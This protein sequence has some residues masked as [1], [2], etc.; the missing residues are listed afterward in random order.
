VCERCEE[1]SVTIT[2]RP[3][4]STDGMKVLAIYAE[5]I[6]GRDATF[7]TNV[8]T[9]SEWNRAHLPMHRLV[10]ID[11]AKKMLGWTA[12]SKVSERREYAG[13]VECHT[14]VRADAQRKG[15]GTALL[16][17]L[18]AATEG[19]GLWTLQA[20]VFPENTPA[21]ALC[22]KVGFEVVGTRRRMGR[23]RGRWRDVVLLERRSPAVA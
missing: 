19:Q 8:P 5:A 23:H 6:K 2:V 9:W 3:L 4:E 7:E 14:F 16:S 11:G 22:A 18:I 12:L 13:I 10:A 15:V 17:G 20:H 21:L 1:E